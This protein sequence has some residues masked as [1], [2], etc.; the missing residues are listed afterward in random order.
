M[1][2]NIEHSLAS[3]AHYFRVGLIAGIC[4]PDQARDWAMTVIGQMDEPPGEVI[5]VSWRKPQERLLADLKAVKGDVDFSLLCRW[6][7]AT[8][9]QQLDAGNMSLSSAMRR[10]KVIASATDSVDLYETL[11]WIEDGL[12]LADKEF[13]GMVEQY[14]QEFD[15]LLGQQAVAPPF[16]PAAR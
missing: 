14:R 7:L 8:L 12:Y 2:K 6:L 3:V 15:Q 5:E 10:A 13:C 16:L 11:D 9:A 1:E 4:T